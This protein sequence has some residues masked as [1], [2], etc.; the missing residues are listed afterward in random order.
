MCIRDSFGMLNV[1]T[2]SNATDFYFD[3]I[4]VGNEIVDMSPPVLTSA[5]PINAT[6]VDVLFDEELDQTS[7]ET[8]G[9]YSLNPA[10]T[11]ST[12]VLDGGN[13]ALV[14]LTL[15][16]AMSNGQSYTLT[17]DLVADV[18]LNPSGQQSD[19]FT[20]LIADQPAVGDVLIN[21]FMCDPSPQVG[22]PVQEFVEIYNKSN[23]IF[24][25]K[26]WKI[27][28]ASGEGTISADW[29]MPCLLYTSPSPRD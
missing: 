13:P 25:V 29:L 6:Q 18:S 20:F 4:Y 3:T 15:A 26:D 28:D 12:A 19:N 5:T 22:L 23:K 9:N 14:H 8:A 7:A 2:V 21:E 10:I 17:S 16:S 1:Y 24:N 11:V 27:S